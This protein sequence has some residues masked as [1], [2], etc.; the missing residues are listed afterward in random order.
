VTLANRLTDTPAL[1][2]GTVCTVCRLLRDLPED[3]RVTL[4]DALQGGYTSRQIAEALTA[5]GQPVAIG[6]VSRHRRG[7]CR[8]VT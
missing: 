5:E 6:T 7:G 4:R 2:S 1:R 8:G 3:D